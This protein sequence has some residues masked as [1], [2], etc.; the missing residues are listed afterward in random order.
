MAKVDYNREMEQ[1]IAAA[2]PGGTLL[3]HSCCGPCATAVLERLGEHFAVTLYFY[4]PNIHPEAEY[5]RRLEAQRAVVEQIQTRYPSALLVAPYDPAPFLAA[6]AGLE[7][8]SEGGARCTRCYAFR[9]EETARL[10]QERGC[11]YFTTTL[12]IGPTKDAE[13]LNEIGAALGKTY[14]VSYLPADFKKKGGFQR[15]V[16][17][18]EE[19]GIYRQTYCGCKDLLF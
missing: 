13:R 14:G 2:R 6:T 17:L 15:S 10:A 5:E 12:S 4:N 18:S 7:A 3:L 16:A 1:Q 8:E 11:D 19:L 9:L